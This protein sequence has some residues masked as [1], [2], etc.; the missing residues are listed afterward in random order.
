MSELVTAFPDA[1]ALPREQ[2]AAL[3]HALLKSAEAEVD[4]DGQP[5]LPPAFLAELERR[6]AAHR[7]DP[8]TAI[9][10]AV[11]KAELLARVKK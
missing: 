6:V 2:R 3:G 9:P 5:P 11:V 10:W 7:A 4:E 1:F 8:S